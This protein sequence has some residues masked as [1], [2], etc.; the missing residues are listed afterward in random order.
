[1]NSKLALSTTTIH[2]AVAFVS[3]LSHSLWQAPNTTRVHTAPTH[4][5]LAQAL[6]G[7]TQPQPQAALGS[8]QPP[9]TCPPQQPGTRHGRSNYL[10]VQQC[11][12]R[13]GA[14][15]REGWGEI[16]TWAAEVTSRS[17]LS[18][19]DE[20]ALD[21][22]HLLS[23]R[24]SLDWVGDWEGDSRATRW[25]SPASSIKKAG[26]GSFLCLVVTSWPPY[27]LLRA[28]SSSSSL[29]PPPPPLRVSLSET[30]IYIFLYYPFPHF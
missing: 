17:R 5:P 16:L 8:T 21:C 1:M 20:L 2:T 22:T 27:L 13:G 7:S 25:Y 19:E 11:R 23:S 29:P 9:V 4:Q 6:V 10:D 30:F 15:W 26:K 14:G 24:R 28:A 12:G 3:L 18:S